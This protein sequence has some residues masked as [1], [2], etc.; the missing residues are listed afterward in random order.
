MKIKI[1]QQNLDSYKDKFK[2]IKIQFR[3][4]NKKFRKLVTSYKHWNM[5]TNN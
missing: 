2:N 1:Q 5:Q 3:I 4:Q